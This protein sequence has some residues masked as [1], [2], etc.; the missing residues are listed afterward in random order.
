MTAHRALDV[1]ALPAESISSQAPAWWGQL[2]LTFI[3]GSM[4]FILLAMYFYYRLSYD[5]WPPPGVQLPDEW[6]PGIALIPLLASVV[7]SYVASEGAKKDSRS[8]MF[9]GLAINVVLAITFLVLRVLEWSRWNFTWR[10][11]SFGSIYWTIMGL[12]T[13]DAV[14]DVI[15][16]IV[17]LVMVAMGKTGPKQR[18]GVHVDSIVWYFIVLIWLPLYVA[19]YWGPHI[20]GA[21]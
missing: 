8:E 1:S 10:A 4:F 9:F 7:G 20:V 12:H 3:E 18:L 11:G 21:P 16:T 13:L 2:L 5:M 17:L 19:L 14:A 15:F 6:I